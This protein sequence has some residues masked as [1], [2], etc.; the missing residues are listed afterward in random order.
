M[1]IRHVAPCTS[2][3]S[4]STTPHLPLT[5]SSITQEVFFQSLLIHRRRRSTYCIFRRCQGLAST[6]SGLTL[7]P[8]I[9]NIGSTILEISKR[10]I[11]ISGGFG[12]LYLGT[13][14]TAGKVALKRPRLVPEGQDLI[15]AKVRGSS[16]LAFEATNTY[17]QIAF[18][19][20]SGSLARAYAST[21]A[22]IHRRRRNRRLYPFGIPLHRQWHTLGIYEK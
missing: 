9:E 10:P 17:L 7:F 4:P 14:A 2:S 12:D 6:S 8:E 1:P 3:P 21:C 13:H 16:F 5:M 19:S 15:V 20:R 11:N 22:R 18:S